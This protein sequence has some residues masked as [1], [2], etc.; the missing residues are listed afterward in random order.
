MSTSNC[1]G[2]STAANGSEMLVLPSDSRPPSNPTMPVVC[3]DWLVGHTSRCDGAGV[4]EKLARFASR[5][6]ADGGA[7][8]SIQAAIPSVRVAASNSRAR[9]IGLPTKYN[10]I[11][12]LDLEETNDAR[13]TP[14]A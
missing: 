6:G 4:S 3:C 1:C 12:L 9:I 10:P 5:R 13:H 11:L 14:A 2:S 8:K 7:V